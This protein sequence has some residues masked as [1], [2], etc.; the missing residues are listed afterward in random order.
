MTRITSSQKTYPIPNSRRVSS[1]SSNN[2]RRG[3]PQGARDV[4]RRHADRGAIR[5]HVL[6]DDRVGTDRH[7]I[8]DR[9]R[10]NDLRPS[11]DE[12]PVAERRERPSLGPERDLMFNL[13]VRGTDNAAVDYHAVGV[14][15]DETRA[16]FG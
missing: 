7:V 16:K 9:H 3:V 1:F 14:N 15:E 12:N 8:A 11:A 4:P 13:H 2:G 5:R 6:D 10:A